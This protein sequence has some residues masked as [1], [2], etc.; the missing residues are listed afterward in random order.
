MK[1]FFI[2]IINS[3]EYSTTFL[4]LLSYIYIGNVKSDVAPYLLTLANRNNPICVA[5]PKVAKA[6]SVT[7]L[8]RVDVTDG[9]VTNIA[10]VNDPLEA[11]LKV[12]NALLLI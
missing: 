12:A 10:N 4:R 8:L 1:L 3:D 9:F 11:A 2:K 5:F 7:W 6:S